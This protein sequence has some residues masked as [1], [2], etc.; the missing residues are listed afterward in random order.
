MA[1][2]KKMAK[3]MK[4]LDHAKYLAHQAGVDSTSALVKNG[5]SPDNIKEL[6]SF[7]EI[8]TDNKKS[9]SVLTQELFDKYQEKIENG[10]PNKLENYI[11]NNIISIKRMIDAI[12][13]Y[14]D[15]RVFEVSFKN[16]Q[17]NKDGLHNNILIKCL[18]HTTILTF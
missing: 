5:M 15:P 12:I 6:E 18:L 13:Q 14:S 11:M 17:R 8:G 9:A 2:R 16:L 1:A 10:V 7:R 4:V 3:N